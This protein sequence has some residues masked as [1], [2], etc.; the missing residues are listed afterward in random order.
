MWK[1]RLIGCGQLTTL[2]ETI[3]MEGAVKN[4]Q[5]R[6]DCEYSGLSNTGVHRALLWEGESLTTPARPLTMS[7]L[8]YPAR[9]SPSPPP[10]VSHWRHQVRPFGGLRTPGTSTADFKGRI[11]NRSWMKL[12]L[13]LKTLPHLSHFALAVRYMLLSLPA[14][15]ATI[16]LKLWNQWR[17]PRL[18]PL[19]MSTWV[20]ACTQQL[21]GQLFNAFIFKEWIEKF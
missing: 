1:C 21:V 16:L 9:Q 7:L 4:D 10:H 2:E 12:I 13:N 18:L 15:P 8:H 20:W 11:E 3:P 14:K 17:L 6:W 5:L 19:E